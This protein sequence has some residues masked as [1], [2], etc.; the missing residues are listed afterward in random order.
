MGELQGKRFIV[1]G[2]AAGIGQAIVRAYLDADARVASLDVS[3]DNWTGGGNQAVRPILCDVSRRAEVE[4]AIAEAVEWMGGLD[5]LVNVAGVE[6]YAPAEEQQDADIDRVIAVN[7]MGT[8]YTNQT[9]FPHLKDGGGRIINFTSAAGV[10]G[11]KN[12]APYAATKGAVASWTRSLATEWGQHNITVN[13]IAPVM[14]SVMTQRTLARLG[15]E[16]AA[17]LRAHMQQ[18]LPIG[19]WFG[20][21]DTDL[22]PFLVFLAGD[23]SRFMTGQTYAI[24]GGRVMMAS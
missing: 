4:A 8:I 2:G 22:A 21:P 1:T 13:A 12:A 17:Q 10:R 23:G 20:E 9:V 15:D 7:L 16:G 24:D 14:N 5:G 18:Y 19:G 11:L 3:A 6:H